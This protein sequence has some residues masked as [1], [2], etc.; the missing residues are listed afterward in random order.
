MTWS[1]DHVRAT[2]CKYSVIIQCCDPPIPAY[3]L[4]T[5][6]ENVARRLFEQLKREEIEAGGGGEFSITLYK[7]NKKTKIKYFRV[8]QAEGGYDHPYVYGII[9]EDAEELEDFSYGDLAA[10]GV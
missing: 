9:Y 6:S 8:T 5:N 10:L 4:N 2:S 1:Q 3:Y 7:H